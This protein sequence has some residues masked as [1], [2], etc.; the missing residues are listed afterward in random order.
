MS[1]AA[2]H[3]QCARWDMSALIDQAIASRSHDATGWEDR[4]QRLYQ[5]ARKRTAELLLAAAAV[6]L[7]LFQTP[8]LWWAAAP[9]QTPF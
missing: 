8:A 5:T 6:Y 4:L 3:L 2:H 9:L 7:L 1:S